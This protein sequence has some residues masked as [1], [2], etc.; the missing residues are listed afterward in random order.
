[1]TSFKGAAY[2]KSSQLEIKSDKNA[3]LLVVD[4]DPGWK[5]TAVSDWIELIASESESGKI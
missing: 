2:Q 5:L 1:M 4:A 3:I